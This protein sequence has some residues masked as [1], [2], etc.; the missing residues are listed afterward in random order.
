[1][2][3]VKHEGANRLG[4]M[5]VRVCVYIYVCVWVAGGGWQRH[6]QFEALKKNVAQVGV[7]LH[8]GDQ[9]NATFLEA[10][11]AASNGNGDSPGFDIILDDG[12]HSM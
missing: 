11:V 1:M 2:L 4:F 10:L 8:H 6:L 12:G 3:A 5:R 9:A 7:T